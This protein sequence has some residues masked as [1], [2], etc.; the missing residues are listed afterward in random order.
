MIKRAFLLF[1][2]LA[3]IMIIS[4]LSYVHSS[5]LS[6]KP[7][8][9]TKL[10][11]YNED[12]IFYQHIQ[13][14]NIADVDNSIATL[15]VIKDRK[16]YLLSDGYD[17][18]E[19]V[20]LQKKTLTLQNDLI[21]DLWKNKLDNI[22]DYVLITDR[23]TPLIQLTKQEDVAAKFGTFF[24]GI[25]DKF[26][27]KHVSIF[28]TLM[29]NRRDSEIQTFRS[30]IPRKIHDNTPRKFKHSAIVK[31][32]DEKTYYAEDADGDGITE[33]FTVNIPDGF[34][35]GFDSGA[36]IIFIL[37]NKQKEITDI[38][39]KLAHEAYY[40]TAEEVSLAKK[41]FP[42]EDEIDTMI[43]NIYQSNKIFEERSKKARINKTE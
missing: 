22:P 18:Y 33:T 1:S 6:Y 10:T 21:T 7:F 24:K 32:I 31:T 39:G 13:N 25:R 3:V 28:K 35:W 8:N 9:L 16:I 19:N 42:K 43:N 29:I 27:K 36:N 23:R 11:R 4:Q 30:Q 38:I 40:G 15:L 41:T 2:I 34:T 5:N 37:N 12:R 14:K 20:Y 26:L 17:S